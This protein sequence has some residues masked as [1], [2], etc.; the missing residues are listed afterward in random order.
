MK[1]MLGQQ[2]VQAVFRVDI[3]LKVHILI[4]EVALYLLILNYIIL[5]DYLIQLFQKDI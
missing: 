2:L 5:V 1:V 4:T 3:H